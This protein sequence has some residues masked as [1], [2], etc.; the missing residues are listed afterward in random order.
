MFSYLY[1]YHIHILLTNILDST[2]SETEMESSIGGYDEEKP[3]NAIG[4]GSSL[5][6]MIDPETIPRRDLSRGGE[7]VEI[8]KSNLVA[9][10]GGSS[11]RND[12]RGLFATELIHNGDSFLC[13]EGEDNCTVI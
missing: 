11:T 1:T 13:Y 4:I 2:E 12:S 8:R 6:A 3:Q 7:K 10:D 9:L 5:P